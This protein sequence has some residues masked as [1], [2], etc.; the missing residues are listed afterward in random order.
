MDKKMH[1][2]PH[3]PTPPNEIVFFIPFIVGGVVM[4]VIFFGSIAGLIWY[5]RHRKLQPNF[6]GRL[7]F[8]CY[9]LMIFMII[10]RPNGQIY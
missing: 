1:E 5:K 8:K 7:T 6:S 10:S 4:I 9:K 2:I 3:M